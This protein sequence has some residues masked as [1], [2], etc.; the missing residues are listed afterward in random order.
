MKSPKYPEA[1]TIARQKTGEEVGKRLALEKQRYC[2]SVWDAIGDLPDIDGFPELLE[3]DSVLF[4]PKGGSRYARILRGDSADP[5]DFSY[6]RRIE[7]GRLTSSLRSEH[8]A[9]SRKRFGD[10]RPGDTE[11]ISRF[12]KL[13]PTGICNT[14]RA[15]TPS[16]RGAFTSPRPIHPSF[17]RCI[18]VREAARLHSYP[19]WF[20]FHMTKWHGFRQIGNSVPPLLARA[21]AS[22]IVRALREVPSVPRNVLA[23]PS[24]ELLRVDMKSAAVRYGV[25][26]HVIEPRVREAARA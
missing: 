24:I 14:I 21:V 20:R 15:G 25:S 19:D 9:L 12:F 22:E 5:G 17:P 7:A 10:T 1:I 8:T 2:P 11:P 4:K 3:N 6:V 23:T 13:A 18:S 26:P 16:N